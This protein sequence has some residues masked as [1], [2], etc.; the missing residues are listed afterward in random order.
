M[1]LSPQEKAEHRAIF[2]QLTPAKKLDHIL[3]YYKIPLILLAFALIVL[4]DVCWR[5]FTKK[6]TLLYAAYSNVAV[7]EELDRALTEDFI[8]Y[9]GEN[10]KKNQV[11]VYRELYLSSDPSTEN[12]QYA[13]ASRLKLLATIQAQEID[14]VLMNQEAYDFLSGEGYLAELPPL[15][16]SALAVRLEPLLTANTVILEDNSIELT[17]NEADAYEAVTEE[18]VNALTVNGLPLFQDAG[19]PGPVYLGVIGNTPRL[20]AVLEYLEYLLDA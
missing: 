8:A 13:Y 1:K 4:G 14:L 5:H 7:G 11:Q 6:E 16:D 20:P 3:T 18:A 10:P 9:L 15:L 12:H 17:L 2:R 19:F